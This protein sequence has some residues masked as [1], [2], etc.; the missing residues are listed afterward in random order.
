M[1]LFPSLAC[2]T[3]VYEYTF[4]SIFI[5]SVAILQH[6][7]FTFHNS[8]VILELVPSTMIFLDSAQMPYLKWQWIFSFSC[9]TW[10]HSRFLVVSVLL[11]VF[12]FMC[13][14]LCF[15]YLR[16]MYPV[17]NSAS[18]SGLS[19]CYISPSVFS[20]VCLIYYCHFHLPWSRGKYCFNYQQKSIWNGCVT[21][22][23]YSVIT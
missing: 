1:E 22:V 14:L 23:Y 12:S 11:I 8:Y 4:D 2:H 16:P 15:V 18:V 3:R 13:C 7:K 17:P 6:M 10:I 21:L 20:N 9:W 19:I 5:S